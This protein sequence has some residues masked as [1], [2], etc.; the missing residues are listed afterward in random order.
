[1][2]G[3]GGTWI[4]ISGFFGPSFLGGHGFLASWRLGRQ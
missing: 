2:K 4:C 3:V 1:M